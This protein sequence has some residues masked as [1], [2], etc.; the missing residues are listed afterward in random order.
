MLRGS[1]WRSCGQCGI[2]DAGDGTDRLNVLDMKASGRDQHRQLAGSV[3]SGSFAVSG[4][5]RAAAADTR[6]R[7]QL[8]HARH[9]RAQGSVPSSRTPLRCDRRPLRC[10]G[11]SGALA[12][13]IRMK[14]A[15]EGLLVY[16][17]IGVCKVY[18]RRAGTL[19]GQAVRC[20]VTIH[21]HRSRTRP[22]RSWS[23]AISCRGAH[24]LRRLFAE[25]TCEALENAGILPRDCDGA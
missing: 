14:D 19:T 20:G 3:S 22:E 7:R 2:G 8:P 23:A 11:R 24:S 15:A 16:A 6:H 18:F 13:P 10:P 17:T 9:G 12:A 1:R 21:R 5:I 25:V 4:N